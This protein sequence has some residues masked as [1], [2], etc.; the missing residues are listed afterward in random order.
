M[1][2]LDRCFAALCVHTRRVAHATELQD[3]LTPIRTLFNSVNDEKRQGRRELFDRP[4][5]VT[6]NAR[7]IREQ[8]ASAGRDDDACEICDVL[9]RLS[10]D[11]RIQGS[12]R[13]E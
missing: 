1:T 10:D 6:P 9:R 12:L 13:R 8:A 5:K 11:P 2:I 7:A 3:F 4:R